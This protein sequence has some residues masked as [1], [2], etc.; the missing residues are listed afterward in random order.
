MTLPRSFLKSASLVRTS[1]S[2]MTVRQKSF[3]TFP[4]APSSLV[5]GK[6][7]RRLSRTAARRCGCQGAGHVATQPVFAAVKT[8]GSMPKVDASSAAGSAVSAAVNVST[9]E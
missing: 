5:D 7:P 2:F 9:L 1:Q 6:S 8:R 4:K 3:R